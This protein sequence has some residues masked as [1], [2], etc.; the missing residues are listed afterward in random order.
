MNDAQVKIIL[1]AINKS[2]PAIR[3]AEKDLTGMAK[4]GEKAAGMMQTAL[5]ALGLA[6]SVDTVKRLAELGASSR[7]QEGVLQSLAAQAGLSGEQILAAM[8]KAAGGTV[9]RMDLMGVA[10]KVLVSGL[11]VNAE[12][13]AQLMGVAK[14]RA[15]AM[16][17]STTQA[18]EMITSSVSMLS[19]RM[20]KSLGIIIDT[21]AAYTRYAKT[22]GI[23][24]DDLSENQMQQALLNAVLEKTSGELG[25]LS[26]KAGEADDA[27]ERLTAQAQNFA[28]KVGRLMT[29]AVTIAAN[30][31]AEFLQIA[32]D[33]VS[34]V[35]RLAAVAEANRA[36]MEAYNR[37]L[38]N[39]NNAYFNAHG[40]LPLVT[41]DTE[42]L[43]AKTAA[44][45]EVMKKYPE[46]FSH[47]AA[48]VKDLGAS[49]KDAGNNAEQA[50]KQFEEARKKVMEIA[51]QKL[52]VGIEFLSGESGGAEK[53]A[54]AQKHAGEQ[55]VAAEKTRKESLLD[56]DKKYGQEKL[57]LEQA[58]TEKIKW[59]RDG[60][61]ER[62]KKEEEDAEAFWNSQFAK[63]MGRLELDHQDQ[64][65]KIQ[66][67]YDDEK[68][69][70]GKAT[71]EARA[72]EDKARK[73][74]AE[75]MA[76]E[77]LAQ[78][79]LLEQHFG[80]LKLT[81]KDAFDAIKSGITPMT[82][83]L[84]MQLTA[85]MSKIKGEMGSVKTTA[86]G[87][88]TVL[89]AAYKLAFESTAK[90]SKEKLFEMKQDT[91]S[92]R[93]GGIQH[94]LG[95][96]KAFAISLQNIAN[97]SGSSAKAQQ[98]DLLNVS[99]TGQQTSDAM[100]R[101]MDYIE[102]KIR[103]GTRPQIQGITKDINDIP[104]NT[105]VYVTVHQKTVYDEGG[106]GGSSGFGQ[107]KPPIPPN[108][109]PPTKPNEYA[110]GGVVPGPRGSPQLAVVHG[111]EEVLTPEQRGGGG[112]TGAGMQ[113]YAPYSQP[114]ADFNVPFAGEYAKGGVV[115]GPLGAPARAIVHGGEEVLT[116]GGR[117]DR[118]SGPPTG[119][120]LNDAQ[121]LNQQFPSLTIPQFAKGGVMP[122]SLGAP[123]LAVLH[124]GEEVLTPE[125]RGRG[126]G[127]TVFNQQVTDA[128][129]DNWNQFK[130]KIADDVRPQIQ[131]I[132]KDIN[133]IPRQTDVYVT[134]HESRVSDR[135]GGRKGGG[136]TGAGI[137]AYVPYSQPSADFN[138]PFAGEFTK[139]GVVPGPLGSP[140]RAIIHGGEEV[141]ATGGR[142]VS[143]T[144]SVNIILQA[145]QLPTAYEWKQVAGK[146][147][148]YLRR[149]LGR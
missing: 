85:A 50:A 134:I 69:I 83:E 71:A 122:G 121:Q 53:L 101:Q 12:Q 144:V 14:D 31:L 86:A 120:A 103:D 43:K 78:K 131:G 125:Q 46:Y 102:G 126:R 58:W 68:A 91:D 115:P 21:D 16:G 139:G 109:E 143:G 29:P 146:L 104:K 33:G 10:S 1:D 45:A 92:W 3:E 88:A 66:K 59:V 141:G 113:A 2:R 27:L 82:G 40:Y 128:V 132:T 5:G 47:G 56:L 89:D 4:T 77:L 87:N 65:A 11:G 118:G 79:G 111:G 114:S 48:A 75:V 133:D 105:D 38:V 145:L 80:G 42:A 26:G 74:R 72:A 97:T 23:A 135:E 19:P 90:T 17:L 99:L 9:A 119:A 142:G 34:E 130:G 140:A 8:D 63:K 20:L 96:E 149:A 44:M 60:A 32:G 30:A 61:H 28:E 94:A 147:E 51:G 24:K 39:A 108:G 37:T 35:Q 67:R 127:T 136:L 93:T 7:E 62:T 117:D 13:M 123:G 73:E 112:L 15:D 41:D 84:S 49:A 138:V 55:V 81:G 124:G 98:Q 148:P 137:Q 64:L 57:D 22:L 106:G 110:K 25:N 70:V 52:K 100:V 54:D 36:G 129:T 6:I 76:L 18:F 116:P 95:V 107:N